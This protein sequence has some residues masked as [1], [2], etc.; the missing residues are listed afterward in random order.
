MARTPA[1]TIEQ[2][3]KAFYGLR[4]D[5]Q[6][7]IAQVETEDSVVTFSTDK[8]AS[9]YAMLFKRKMALSQRSMNIDLPCRTGRTATGTARFIICA[10]VRTGCSKLTTK[11]R[12]RCVLPVCPQNMICRITAMRRTIPVLP[13]LLRQYRVFTLCADRTDARI[14]A[15][16]ALCRLQH[17][18]DGAGEDVD[19]HPPVP[20]PRSPSSVQT[21][22]L[23]HLEF[24]PVGAEDLD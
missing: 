7:Q 10:S 6:T 5:N 20:L 16:A 11:A 1:P 13:L 3:K 9:V 2:A 14:N 24:R 8:S 21:R 15:Y 22:R 4:A 12:H 18:L 23:I 19:H 17:D